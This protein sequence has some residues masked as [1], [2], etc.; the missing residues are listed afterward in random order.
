MKRPG[1]PRRRREIARSAIETKRGRIPKVNPARR[2]KKAAKYKAF[3]SSAV[4]KRM[5]KEALERAEYQCEATRV[6]YSRFTF[7]E[8]VARCEATE[9]LTVHHLSY[10][11]FGGDELPEDLQ[12]LCKYCH[13]RHSALTGKRKS[14]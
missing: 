14:A 11:R 6:R 9:K 2:A 5:R 10:A 12:V 3:L 13:D 4:W 7:M 8:M 1:L